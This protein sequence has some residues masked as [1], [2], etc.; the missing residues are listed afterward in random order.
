MSKIEMTQEQRMALMGALPFSGDE[1]VEFTPEYFQGVEEQ[2]RPVFH[3][4][5]LTKGLHDEY[6]RAE[7]KAKA[8]YN[9][10]K[11]SDADSDKGVEKIIK[12]CLT[13]WENFIDLANMEL[14]QFVESDDGGCS[15]ESYNHLPQTLAVDILLFVLKVSGLSREE[16]RSLA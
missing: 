10:G 7:R 1:S 3:V 11:A 15:D 14:I 12:Y 5:P 16:S 4:R 8:A 13:G 6:K 2:F 9:A